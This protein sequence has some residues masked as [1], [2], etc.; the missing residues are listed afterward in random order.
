[1]FFP[2]C[3]DTNGKRTIMFPINS[4]MDCFKGFHGPSKVNQKFYW[5]SKDL[6]C[7]ALILNGF[8]WHS[9]FLVFCLAWKWSFSWISLTGA[10]F[11]TNSSWRNFLSTL[12]SFRGAQW[13][14][15]FLLTRTKRSVLCALPVQ[16]W[17]CS[18]GCSSVIPATSTEK[19]GWFKRRRKR[20]GEQSCG[21]CCLLIAVE[22][23]ALCT[24]F[25]IWSTLL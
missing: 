13:W 1:M 25:V 3:I 21:V 23:R 17:L 15:T 9:K 4:K 8:Q 20:F 5:T 11:S 24:R 18:V 12:I 22:F 2:T 19:R 14:K 6:S 16:H 7:F 10:D